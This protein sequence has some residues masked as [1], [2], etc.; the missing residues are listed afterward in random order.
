MKKGELLDR[1]LVLVTTKFAGIYDKAGQ[2]YVL[3]CLKVMYYVKSEDEEL[4][5][6]ALG[7]DLLEDTNVTYE[8]LEINFNKR[9][10]DGILAM[11][12]HVALPPEFYLEQIKKNPDAIRVKLADLRHNSDIRRLKGVTQ[13]DIE[14]IVKYHKMYL[15]LKELA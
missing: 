9:I 1:M 3:H 7:H 11:T 8:Y 4:L 15:E 14:R 5:C 10:A 13:K 12:K 2:P 6:I